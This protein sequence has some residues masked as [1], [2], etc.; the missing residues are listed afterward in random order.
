MFK[1][2][3]KILIKRSL[4]FTLFV[5]FINIANGQGIKTVVIDP[6]HG[7]KDPGCHGRRTN[8]KD[9]CLAIALQLGK[10]LKEK[11]PD[12]NVIFTRK[13][14]V[15]VKL[16]DRSR[17]ANENHAD[18][19]I[20]IHV[21]SA[22]PS[23][24]GIETF[25]LG[26]H[27]TKEQQA[28]AEK[29]NAAILFE[30]NT[31]SINDYKLSSDAIIARKLQLGSYL[32]H[33]INFAFQVQTELIKDTKRRDRKIKQAGFIVLYRS[34]MPSILIETG[35]LTNKA[36]EE[37]LRNSKNQAKMAR[38]IVKAFT[39]YKKQFESV[40]KQISELKKKCEFKVQIISSKRQ[41]KLIPE[42][43]KGLKNV[44]EYISNGFYK[45]TVGTYSSF[46][47]AF[48]L[49]KDLRK[50]KFK[51]AFVIAFKNGKRI[52]INEAKSLSKN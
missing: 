18:L 52:P 10:K 25:V 36:E 13:K 28:V 17:I 48:Q 37:F 21:N 7:G 29:E 45:Y 22:S 15:F 23:A 19:F 30:D 34:T 39:N 2:S 35:F 40:D 6:G 11:H 43:F 41:I 27:K 44:D 49:Q 33:S 14:D 9:I 50:K 38:S 5:L 31:K 51:S 1:M 24:H 46:N 20:S 32:D 3:L 26:L 47:D 4:I 16:E 12:I 8:E 42:N